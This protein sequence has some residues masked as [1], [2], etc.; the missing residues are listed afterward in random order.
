MTKHLHFVGFR[1]D[2]EHLSAVKVWGHPDFIHL[3]HD[4]RMWG[5]IGEDDVVVFG[6]KGKEEA[7]EVSWQDHEL[8]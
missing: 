6:S 8:W 1:S 3:I 7:G 2:H 4:H 5:D